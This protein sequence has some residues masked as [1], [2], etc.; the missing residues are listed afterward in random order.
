MLFDV[1]R[2]SSGKVRMMHFYACLGKV[3]PVVGKDVFSYLLYSRT[4]WLSDLQ[5]EQL[6]LRDRM[7][8]YF[9]LD[10]YTRTNSST[11][12]VCGVV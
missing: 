3:V 8:G 11:W 1:S 10:G 5:I 4:P 12:G 2:D 6:V 9:E 7:T